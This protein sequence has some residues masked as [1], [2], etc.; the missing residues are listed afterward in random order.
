MKSL[1]INAAPTAP[2]SETPNPNRK[3]VNQMIHVGQTISTLR[4]TFR[5]TALE[6]PS[7]GNPNAQIVHLAKP[8]GNTVW[9]GSYDPVADKVVC[10]RRAA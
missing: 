6:R 3:E 8:A 7:A 9:V 5:I 4:G 10:V 1:E 2:S